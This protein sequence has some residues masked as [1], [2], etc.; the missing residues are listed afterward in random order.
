MWTQPFS[1][2]LGVFALL[3]ATLSGCSSIDNAPINR[4]SVLPRLTQVNTMAGDDTLRTTIVGLAF[5][6]GGTRAAA[7]SFG[8]LKGLDQVEAPGGGRLLDQVRFV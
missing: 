7:F 2:A 1:R 8:V 5:S 4:P 3:V 6:G